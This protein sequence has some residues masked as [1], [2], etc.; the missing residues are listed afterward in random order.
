MVFCTQL[1][2]FSCPQSWQENLKLKSN[3][4]KA[5]QSTRVI[6]KNKTRENGFFSLTIYTITLPSIAIELLHL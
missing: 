5:I 4:T 6:I 3:S 2:Q 1:M